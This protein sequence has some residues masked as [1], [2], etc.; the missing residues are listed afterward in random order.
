LALQLLQRSGFEDARL[1]AERLIDQLRPERLLVDEGVDLVGGVTGLIGPLLLA[2]TSRAQE[3]AVL[4]GERLLTLQLDSG[5]WAE[6][7]AATQRKPPLTGFSHGAAGMAAALA[8]LFRATGESRFAEGAARALGY[9]RSVFVAERGNWPDF[10][11]SNK[12]DSFMLSWCHG[13]PGILI[14]RHV[15]KEAGLADTM[16]ES[17]L[18]V[19]RAST[20]ALLAERRGSSLD[21]A[22][23]LCCGL[24]GLT[25]LLRLD[26]LASGL[27]LEPV[28]AS[29]ESALIIRAR[30]GAG[31]T[32]FSVDQGSL[33]LP[34]LFTGKAGVALALLEASE[35]ELWLPAVLSAG[36]FDCSTMK[37]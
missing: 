19:A 24:L 31:Y 27:M 4:C 29:V 17:E 9:E 5:G 8:R 18:G 13:A 25:S 37:P 22:A 20:L 6:N 1:L 2:G 30:A 23:H 36:L 34:G 11:S 12:P 28:V 15:M 26:A 3:L 33:N 10:R 32:F 16:C 14:A 35:G 7:A 21:V